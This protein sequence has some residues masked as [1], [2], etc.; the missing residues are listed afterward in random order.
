MNFDK[1]IYGYYF[2]TDS[3]CSSEAHTET[4]GKGIRKQTTDKNV[5]KVWKTEL[6]TFND[7]NKMDDSTNYKN[8]LYTIAFVVILGQVCTN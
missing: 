3:I 5:P 7:S 6:I 8:S 1:F 2:I 4:H